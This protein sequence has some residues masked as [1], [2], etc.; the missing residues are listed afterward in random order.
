MLAVVVVFRAVT[1]STP[2]STLKVLNNAQTEGVDDGRK[3]ER[4]ERLAGALRLATVSY[5]PGKQNSSEF[6]KLHDYLQKGVL[7]IK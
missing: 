3:M 2:F 7:K 4:A 6:F 5:E 1:I